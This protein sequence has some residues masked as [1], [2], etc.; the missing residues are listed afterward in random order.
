MD[1]RGR[2]AVRGSLSLLLIAAC[3]SVLP[4]SPVQAQLA[5][6][7]WTVQGER[8]PGSRRCGEWLVQITNARGQLSGTVSHARAVAIQN[9]TLMPDGSSSGT[10]P[11][12]FR[13]S[14]HAHPSLSPEGFRGTPSASPS[15]P[16]YVPLA[17]AQPLAGRQAADVPREGGCRLQLHSSAS[18]VESPLSVAITTIQQLPFSRRIL[19]TR[20]KPER[21]ERQYNQKRRFCCRFA[22]GAA[23]CNK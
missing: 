2:L 15:K 9:L 12:D 16:M 8:I 7:V 4:T 23:V 10:A 5:D 6:G 18:Q 11:A 17:R 20:W 14:R 3:V 1:R 21:L 19:P 22:A 13:R